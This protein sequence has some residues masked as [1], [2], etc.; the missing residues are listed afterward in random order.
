MLKYNKL[1]SDNK[2]IA[3]SRDIIAKIK[4]IDR[5]CINCIKIIVSNYQY[6]S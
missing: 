1:Q 5:I 6:Q 4:T 3:T 2:L